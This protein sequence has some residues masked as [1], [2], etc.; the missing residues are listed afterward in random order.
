VPTITDRKRRDIIRQ[1]EGLAL[2]I[3][4]ARNAD[5]ADQEFYLTNAQ[6]RLAYIAQAA[7]NA[8][9]AEEIEKRRDGDID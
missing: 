5:T 9:L 2:D 4:Q 3:A 6:T 8:K 7:G 1:V